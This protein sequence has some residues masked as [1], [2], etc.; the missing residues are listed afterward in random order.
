MT[1]A[2]VSRPVMEVAASVMLGCMTMGRRL[3]LALG[4]ALFL[5][6]G[7]ATYAPW[8]PVMTER[9]G[10]TSWLMADNHIWA[11]LS[12]LAGTV[13]SVFALFPPETRKDE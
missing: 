7:W 3:T 10:V 4:V 8:G 9:Q 12:V 2:G 11:L 5:V 13:L 6:G 1:F